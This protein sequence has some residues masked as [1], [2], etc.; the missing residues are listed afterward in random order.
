MPFP[1]LACFAGR[2]TRSLEHALNKQ[3][4]NFPGVVAKR[5]DDDVLA[6]EAQKVLEASVVTTGTNGKTTTNNLMASCMEEA[7]S[8]VFCNRGGSNLETGV[9]TTL[10]DKRTAPFA[11]IECDEMY[12]RFVLPKLRPRLFCLLNLF[13][14]DQI[15]RFGTMDRIFDAVGQA[16]ASSEETALLLNGDDPNCR[17]VTV[18]APKNP[19]ITFGITEACADDGSD[20]FE[21]A[22]CPSCGK[23]L[24]YGLRHYGQLGRWSCPSCGEQAPEP[25]ATARN[26]RETEGGYLIDIVGGTELLGGHVFD[27][28]DVFVPCTGLYMVYNVLAVR[29]ATAILGCDAETFKHVV[30]T[31]DPK[32]GRLQNYTVDGRAILTNMAKNPVGFNQNI[33]MALKYT[34]PAAIAFLMDDMVECNGDYS[35]VDGIEFAQLAETAAQ[36]TPIFYGGEIAEPLRRALEAAHIPTRQA[37]HVSDVL[38]AL[39]AHD[40]RKLFVIANYHALERVCA[41]LDGLAS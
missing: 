2:A 7:G 26:V 17:A 33:H 40:G 30:A 29:V 22:S 12:T 25:D 35:W 32:N 37:D 9:I 8:P 18:R 41:E 10:L 4:G 11:L 19:R 3:A 21:G 38:A 31:F 28:T 16:A 34:E 36:G 23:D 27:V 1:R 15:Y 20:G 24:A 6:F 5:I 14:G 13:P 39:D